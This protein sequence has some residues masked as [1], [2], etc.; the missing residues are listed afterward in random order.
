MTTSARAPITQL[1]LQIPTLTFPNTADE[2]RFERVAEIGRT[3]ERA[4]FDSVWVMDHFYQ[5]RRIGRP[6]DPM[7]EA[8]TLLAGLAARTGRASARS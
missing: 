6:T 8:Y 4:G 7:F 5:I 1:G 3:A 2:D